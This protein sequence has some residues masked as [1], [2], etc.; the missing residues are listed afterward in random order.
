MIAST[1][2]A[3]AGACVDRSDVGGFGADAGENALEGGT[4]GANDGEAGRPTADVVP[5][6]IR[7]AAGGTS[8]C[9]VDA[10]GGAKCWGDNLH[11]ALGIGGFTP[12]T[13]D[14]ALAVSGI[15]S[16]VRAIAGGPFSQCAILVDGTA[17]CWGQSLFGEIAG[18]GSFESVDMPSPHDKTG[19]SN[20]VAQIS[21]GV[22]FGC[23]LT[24]KGRAKCWGSGGAGQLGTG[25]TDDEL[26]ARDVAGL[27]E[28][29]VHLSA[30]MGGLFACAVTAS[31]TVRCW[32]EN[33]GRQLGTKTPQNALPSPVEGL[34]PDVVG[35][36][37]GRSHAC[38]LYKNG[39]IACW[40]SNADAQLGSGKTGPP[41][42]PRKVAGVEAATELFVGSDHACAIV[43]DRSTLCWG[44]NLGGEVGPTPGPLAPTVTFPATF[45][46]V[47]I[48]AGFNH[49]CAINAQSMVSCV[50]SSSR[51]Q[52]G[53]QT[54]SL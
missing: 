12:A 38:A 48:G 47:A 25:R 26:A 13:S 44:S 46:A 33:G 41:S 39:G 42:P 31:G 24:T 11:G 34:E 5:S 37:A 21:F 18:P 6:T 1:L 27:D 14:A 43:A 8:T 50:G 36:G 17:R 28:P 23:A 45:G 29:V 30:S 20:D 16:G 53:T 22:G 54:F 19:L 40:G 9:A 49:T 15:S 51:K 10:K 35:V 7:I 3:A 32:G 4:G 52:T 2:L